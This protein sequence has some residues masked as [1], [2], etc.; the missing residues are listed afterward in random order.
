MKQ[1]ARDLSMA[2]KTSGLY[3]RIGFIAAA[4]I[5]AVLLVAWIN[6]GEEPLHSISVPV[7]APENVQ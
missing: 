6:G 1:E 5:C 3:K 4:V 7:E 2:G